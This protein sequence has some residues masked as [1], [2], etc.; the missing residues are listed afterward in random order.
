[1]TKHLRSHQFEHL[2]W[3][4]K[5]CEK[6][7]QCKFPGCFKSFTAK[8]S[9]QFHWRSHANNDLG[10]NYDQAASSGFTIPLDFDYSRLHSIW[11]SGNQALEPLQTPFQ[12]ANPG[13]SGLIKANELHQQ[14]YGRET[15]GVSSAVSPIGGMP[16]TS[17]PTLSLGSGQPADYSPGLVTVSGGGASKT[18]R[19]ANSLVHQMLSFGQGPTPSP[20]VS[21]PPYSYHGDVMSIP[22]PPLTLTSRH[23][24]YANYTSDVLWSSMLSSHT[25]FH[26]SLRP[27]NLTT[28]ES[29]KR[30]SSPRDMALTV[31]K[32][33]HKRARKA[34]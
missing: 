6:P 1:L 2:R 8:S 7:F 13:N 31:I 5:C 34:M 15:Y 19:F 14:L 9:L 27:G 32:L 4:R 20:S 30:T 24:L 17:N 10:I 11:G 22:T 12:S 18:M 25:S 23:P 29:I 16:L 21:L 28:N 3:N 26:S 33:P